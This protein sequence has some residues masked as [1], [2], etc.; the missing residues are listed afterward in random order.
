VVPLA[1]VGLLFYVYAIVR[2][3]KTW[4][5]R[6]RVNKTIWFVVLAALGGVCLGVMFT[7]TIKH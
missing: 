5:H 3:V 1:I 7:A 2:V 6:D 4:E